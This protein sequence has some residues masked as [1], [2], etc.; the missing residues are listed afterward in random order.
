[1]AEISKVTLPNNKTYYIRDAL[2]QERIDRIIE[3]SKNHIIYYSKTQQ[4]WNQ[5]MNLISEENA[6][7]IYTEYYNE[8]GELK[9]TPG[10]KIGDGINYLYDLPFVH[11]PQFYDDFLSHIGNK[12]IHVTIDE[13]NFWN[14]K[15]NVDTFVQNENLILN[16]D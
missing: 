2:A 6:I 12:N 4:E 9:K 10:I 7:Y 13:K 16:R 8:E 1:M 5:T 14:N 15:I 11:D 3:K